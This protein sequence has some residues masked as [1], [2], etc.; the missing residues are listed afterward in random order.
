MLLHT[1]LVNHVTLRKRHRLVA[2]EDHP[3]ENGYDKSTLPYEKELPN[4]RLV[5]KVRQSIFIYVHVKFKPE[6]LLYI[7]GQFCLEFLLIMAC[8]CIIFSLY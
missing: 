8:I 2:K 4:K 3:F 7:E 5:A 6:L 1:H